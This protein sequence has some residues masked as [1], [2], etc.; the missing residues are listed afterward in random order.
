MD[1]YAM[2]ETGTVRIAVTNVTEFNR[3]LQVARAEAD[4]LNRTIQE[5]SSF[6]LDIK[7]STDADQAGV[8][9]SASS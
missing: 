9:D 1:L 7:F 6:C 4:Q 8:M 3:L 2:K 5:L